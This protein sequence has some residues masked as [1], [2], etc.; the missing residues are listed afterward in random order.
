M[1]ARIKWKIQ[2][3]F[4]KEMIDSSFMLFFS[5]SAYVQQNN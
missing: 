1:K 2:Q 5:H 3:N 4:C